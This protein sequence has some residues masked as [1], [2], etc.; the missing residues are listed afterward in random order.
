M[1]LVTHIVEAM[2][3]VS[4][5]PQAPAEK[6][7]APYVAPAGSP[8]PFLDTACEIAKIEASM[9]F[10]DRMRAFWIGGVE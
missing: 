6:P 2:L 1:P 3:I 10:W 7:Q 5:Q 8:C 4:P 9:T